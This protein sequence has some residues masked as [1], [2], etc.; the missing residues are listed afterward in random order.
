[1]LFSDYNITYFKNQCRVKCS[2]YG[3]LYLRTLLISMIRH[4]SELPIKIYMNI[5]LEPNY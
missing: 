2:K 4:H 5:M 1:M 3:R